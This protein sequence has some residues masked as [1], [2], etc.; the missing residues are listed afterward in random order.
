MTSIILEK[1]EYNDDCIIWIKD[2]T[3]VVWY[4]TD[5]IVE[6]VDA[7]NEVLKPY[8][9]ELK[10]LVIKSDNTFATD[11]LYPTLEEIIHE[12][13]PTVRKRLN[14]NYP[15]RIPTYGM[16]LEDDSREWHFTYEALWMGHLMITG[17]EKWKFY[18]AVHG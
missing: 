13:L 17:Q 4:P 14:P 7:V 6:D 12:T 2:D 3:W 18:K 15:P 8:S 5:S 10:N 11:G 1:L 16:I 9:L